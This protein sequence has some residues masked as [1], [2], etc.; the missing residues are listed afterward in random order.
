LLIYRYFQ[1]KWIV[2]H[3][4]ESNVTSAVT[5][6]YEQH[7]PDQRI[8]PYTCVTGGRDITCHGR[9]MGNVWS[10]DDQIDWRSLI[11][12]GVKRKSG[13]G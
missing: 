12:A 3:F 13:R 11:L 8:Q 5:P 9:P 10:S 7:H 1:Q 4:F 6:K 2:D